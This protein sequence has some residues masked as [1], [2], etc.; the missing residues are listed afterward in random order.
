MDIGSITATISSIKTAGD[1]VN[2]ILELKT[3]DAINAAVREANS[4]LLTVQ[5][6]ALA[7]QSEQFAM[8]EEIRN[9]KEK[10]TDLKKWEAEQKRYKLTSL[11]SI[12]GAVSYSLKES[13]AVGEPPHY[14]CT[15][16]YQKGVKSI[17][18]PQKNKL[19]RVM[20]LC[21]ACGS[22]AHASSHKSMPQYYKENSS[23]G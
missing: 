15:N 1:I 17:L 7:A 13:M 22:E 5:R 20:Y 18:N 4:H 23:K 8:I 9:L 12:T 21:P 14:L 2:S 19:S 10:I 6:E 16:C 11:C 3:S